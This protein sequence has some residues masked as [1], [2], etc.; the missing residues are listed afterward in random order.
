MNVEKLQSKY[1]TYLYSMFS[2]FKK[3]VLDPLLWGRG[4]VV[5]EYPS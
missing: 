1:D 2:S 5:K 3:I 4:T